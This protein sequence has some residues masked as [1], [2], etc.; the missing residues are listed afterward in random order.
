MSRRPTAPQW[1]AEKE[2]FAFTYT[3][4]LFKG[5]WRRGEGLYDYMTMLPVIRISVLFTDTLFRVMDNWQFLLRVCHYYY[6]IHEPLDIYYA[7]LFYIRII[8]V[9]VLMFAYF[10]LPCWILLSCENFGKHLRF[11]HG[12]IVPR[13]ILYDWTYPLNSTSPCLGIQYRV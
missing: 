7:T 6:T 13:S 3:E 10:I 1:V 2:S 4:R 8:Q 11:S 5:S 9:H 12:G